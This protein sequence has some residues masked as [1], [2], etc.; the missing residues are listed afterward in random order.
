MHESKIQ[1][2]HT[3]CNLLGKVGDGTRDAVPLDVAID[4]V[5]PTK[6]KKNMRR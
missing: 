6:T 1:N 3:G 4:A 2:E 5:A